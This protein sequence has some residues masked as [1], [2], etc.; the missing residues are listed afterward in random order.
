MEQNIVRFIKPMA[1][2]LICFVSI[3]YLTKNIGAAFVISLVPLFL[4]WLGI[5]ESLAY[6][7][8]TIVFLAAVGW[9]ATPAGIKSVLAEKADEASLEIKQ[10]IKTQ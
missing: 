3:L 9:A 7:V 2:A 10:Q 5:L 8:A 6:A 4:G 1:L